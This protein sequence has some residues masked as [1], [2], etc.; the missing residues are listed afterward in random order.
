[1]TYATR[2]RGMQPTI[3]DAIEAGQNNRPAY[4]R[5]I[6]FPTSYEQKREPFIIYVDREL[7]D[8]FSGN[9]DPDQL[10]SGRFAHF[11]ATR[12]RP[13]SDELWAACEEWSRTNIAMQVRL[14]DL[15][16]GKYPTRFTRK[17]KR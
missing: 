9:P 11:L 4:V 15:S 12:C 16:R 14:K 13:Y 7:H 10:A 3:E 6:Y 1:M 2:K 8:G 17:D 5:Y